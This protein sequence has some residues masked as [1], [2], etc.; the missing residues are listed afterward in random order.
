MT[1]AKVQNAVCHVAAECCK[2]CITCKSAVTIGCLSRC[3][4]FAWAATPSLH[5]LTPC[6]AVAAPGG[7]FALYAQLRRQGTKAARSGAKDGVQRVKAADWR[8][9]LIESRKSQNV[10]RVLVVLGVGA[11]MGDGVLTP[12]SSVHK[13]RSI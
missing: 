9:R 2:P 5:L 11:I 1:M 6:A 10:L 8:Q 12:V 13:C 3:Y 4:T 7:T